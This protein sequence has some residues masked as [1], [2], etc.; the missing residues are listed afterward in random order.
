MKLFT[1][2]ILASL[3]LVFSSIIYA[4]ND[5]T[6]ITMQLTLVDELDLVGSLLSNTNQILDPVS[7]KP[8]VKK[9]PN[10]IVSLGDLGVEATFTGTCT[11]DFASTNGFMLKHETGPQVY[12]DYQLIYTP[13]ATTYTFAVD[14][15][16][17]L[18]CNTTPVNLEFQAVGNIKKNIKAGRYLDTVMITVTSP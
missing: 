18:P 2:K 10:Q 13:S 12:T 16:I 9:G 11:L 6:K 8:A 3:S 15:S 1:P 4:G 14:T 17:T 7:I 5:N